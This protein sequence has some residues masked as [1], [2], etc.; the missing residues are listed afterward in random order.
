MISS[1]VTVKMLNGCGYEARMFSFSGSGSS[2]KKS[3]IMEGVR[4][5]YFLFAYIFLYP[6]LFYFL[7]LICCWHCMLLTRAVLMLVLYAIQS[8]HEYK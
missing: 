6:S 3:Y 1:F 2:T 4:I 8:G 7:C 5:R